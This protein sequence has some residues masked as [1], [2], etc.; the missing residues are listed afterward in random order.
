MP[1]TLNADRL[2]AGAD[3][4]FFRA[5]LKRW[6]QGLWVVSPAGETLG[7]HYHTP[8]AGDSFK[9]N[10]ARWASDTA[11]M[12]DYAAKQAGEMPPRA[13][14][15]VDPYPDRGHGFAPDG[16]VRLAVSVTETRGGVPY[17][18]PVFDSFRLSAA[19]FAEFAPKPGSDSVEVPEAVARRFAPT[20]SPL[21]DS[22]FCPRPSDLTAAS[23]RGTVLRREP[24]RVVVAYTAELRSRHLRDGKAD[25]PVAAE[26]TGQGVAILGEG[27][28]V[29]RLLW[30]LSGSYQK[31]PGV[32]AVPVAAVVEWAE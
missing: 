16:G 14:K 10:A 12:L 30:V 29:T 8:V 18:A 7:F 17:N 26:L 11:A 3:G 6:P 2:P 25:A 20:L 9:Q 31:G 23:I 21:T 32:S 15:A 24:G 1:V 28:R 19:G 13:P 4:D 27:G 22:I 5:L